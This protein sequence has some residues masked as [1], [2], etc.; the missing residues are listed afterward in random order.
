[1]IFLVGAQFVVLAGRPLVVIVLCVVLTFVVVKRFTAF[2][3]VWTYLLV[4]EMWCIAAILGAAAVMKSPLLSL[5]ASAIAPAAALVIAVWNWTVE[6]IANLQSKG[7]SLWFL[8]IVFLN[9][10]LACVLSMCVAFTLKLVQYNNP[11]DNVAPYLLWLSRLLALLALAKAGTWW[12]MA[13]RL[14]NYQEVDDWLLLT[15][16]VVSAY[17]VPFL[18]VIFAVVARPKLG[19]WPGVLAILASLLVTGFNSINSHRVSLDPVLKSVSTTNSAV[20]ETEPAGD[21]V[22]ALAQ[23]AQC[24]AA[25]RK[26][27]E[28]AERRLHDAVIQA[29]VQGRSVA[30]IARQARMKRHE[31]QHILAQHQ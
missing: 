1:M 23:E 22:G 28:D 15:A 29:S 18:A 13:K 7:H 20:A 12:L 10:A 14:A 11:A 2:G 30:Q 19:L 17:C 27:I 24:Y 9:A 3:R 6:L 25:A 8:L 31:I 4:T 21:D 5:V 26:T 16:R